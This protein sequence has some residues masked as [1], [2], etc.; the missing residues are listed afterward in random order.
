MTVSDLTFV[1]CV[2]SVYMSFPIKSWSV[3]DLNKEVIYQS[4]VNY[5]AI[6]E[7]ILAQTSNGNIPNQA[8]RNPSAEDSGIQN[9]EL[10]PVPSPGDSCSAMDEDLRLALAMS[11]DQLKQE[12]LL[13]KQEEEELQKILEL[14]LSEKWVTN[15]S[16][17]WG[18][19]PTWAF[20]C[21]VYWFTMEPMWYLFS[22]QSSKDLGLLRRT[23]RW[24][25]YVIVV[26]HIVVVIKMSCF[27]NTS[28]YQS[29]E[30]DQYFVT[31]V[32]AMCRCIL[33]SDD[34]VSL[35]PLFKV[36]YPMYE[37]DSGGKMALC[38]NANRCF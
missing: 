16:R 38:I 24:T 14:S 5:R 11:E 10:P 2:V 6:Q 20:R 22:L 17:L 36:L 12:E 19:I 9:R 3:F 31:D 13:R 34:D 4:I 30:C 29:W 8:Q 27:L 33:L 1:I 25:Y 7:S 15:I 32:T 28:W 18:T 23:H 26:I 35:P 37:S 21:L